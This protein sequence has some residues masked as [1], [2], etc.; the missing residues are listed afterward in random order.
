M[1]S[2]FSLLVVTSIELLPTF[3]EVVDDLRGDENKSFDVFVRV[4]LCVVAGGLVTV[5]LRK[6][7]W[8]FIAATNLSLAMHFLLFDYVL[9]FMLIK[10][11]TLEPPRGTTYH[12]FT[13]T[14]KKGFV[15]NIPWWRAANP[16][17]KLAIRCTWFFL[18]S[19]LYAHAYIYT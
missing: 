17:L 6:G 8:V 5:I 13:Y 12:W 1:I 9:A 10:N 18:S 14:A 19:Q 15:D 7:M 2:L 3:W 11:G 4:F 16:W